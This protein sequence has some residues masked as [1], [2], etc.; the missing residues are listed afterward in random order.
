MHYITFIVHAARGRRLSIL[1]IRDFSVPRIF[2]EYFMIDYLIILQLHIFKTWIANET[3]GKIGG[4]VTR[5][6]PN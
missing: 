6:D 2:F 3:L 4:C 1:R 5:S